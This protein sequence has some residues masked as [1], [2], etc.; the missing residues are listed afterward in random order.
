VAAP[1]RTGTAFLSLSAAGVSGH[2][3]HEPDLRHRSFERT[4]F[5]RRARTHDA[6]TIAVA[7]THT[8]KPAAA[9]VHIPCM[10]NPPFGNWTTVAVMPAAM[11]PT[12]A[13]FHAVDQGTGPSAAL[14]ARQ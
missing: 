14:H 5:R 1:T 13:A 8:A 11:S 3:A 9:M 6:T 12:I 4:P 10:L 2:C 7:T